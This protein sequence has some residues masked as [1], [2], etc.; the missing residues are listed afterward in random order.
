MMAT[1]PYTPVK[2]LLF[3]TVPLLA[4]T[5][6]AIVSLLGGLLAAPAVNAATDLMSWRAHLAARAA[7]AA[8]HPP[9]AEIAAALSRLAPEPPSTHETPA[10]VGYLSDLKSLGIPTDD[11]AVAQPAIQLAHAIVDDF[12]A[13]PTFSEV[14][15]VAHD[16]L[17]AGFTSDQVAGVIVYAAKWY[18]PDLLPL[19]KAY[20]DTDGGTS[21]VVVV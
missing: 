18:G 7:V 4:A 6:V 13:N 17:D 14:T 5:V 19:L 11:P 8:V 20:G 9:D 21:Y 16:G 15:S 2:P 10:D 3:S 12:Y 1:G